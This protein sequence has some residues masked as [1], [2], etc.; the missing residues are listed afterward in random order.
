[1]C[2]CVF[3]KQF[4]FQF[5]APLPHSVR[6]VAPWGEGTRHICRTLLICNFH[7]IHLSW[8]KGEHMEL[9]LK[10]SVTRC[11]LYR[12]NF[13]FITKYSKWN[14]ISIAPHTPERELH[15]ATAKAFFSSLMVIVRLVRG[16]G[17]RRFESSCG[18]ADVRLI[19]VSAVYQV[20]TDTIVA[21]FLPPGANSYMRKPF[22]IRGNTKT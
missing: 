21:T 15:F 20:N 14:I 16:G 6:E 9:K 1:M 4:K 11:I 7:E 10:Y 17:A 22:L 3:N 5:C 19:M 13:R 12:Q 2:L 8:G 18:R